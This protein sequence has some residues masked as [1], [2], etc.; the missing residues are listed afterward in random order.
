MSIKNSVIDRLIKI[1]INRKINYK[2]DFGD[3]NPNREDTYILL[4][5]NS[6]LL[7]SFYVSNLLKNKPIVVL[8]ELQ[9]TNRFANYFF[10]NYDFW[11]FKRNLDFDTV[12]VKNIHNSLE[13]NPVLIFPEVETSFF[14]E[15]QDIPKSIAKLIKKEKKDVILC[16]INGSYLSHPRWGLKNTKK[17]LVEFNFKT[18]LTKYEIENTK[19]DEIYEIV[20]DNLKYNDY[21]WNSKHKHFYNPKNRA[22]GLEGYLYIC[23]KC[24]K[25]QTLSTKKND[26]YCS[27][28]GHIASFDDFSLIN[29]LDFDNLVSWDQLQ[30]K[31]LP[32][33]SKEVIYSEGSMFSL[34]P[35]SM[36]LSSLG[37]A[38]LEIIRGQLFVL[39]KMKEYMFEIDKIKGLSLIRRNELFFR[40]GKKSYLF[41]LKDPMIIFDG[42]SYT[43]KN[44]KKSI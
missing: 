38:D 18:I 16:Q 23:P 34:N 11:L 30:K 44:S 3:L 19:L 43:L 27:Q 15:V 2:V 5:N 6:S 36:E 1:Y 39:N 7:N 14:G 41:K 13:K 42:I 20:K 17:G 26:I 21:D 35:K 33:L 8:N 40:Y 32:K 22:L 29:G 37:H 25:S 10:A 31:E 28:C 9:K 4:G 24:M 12:L